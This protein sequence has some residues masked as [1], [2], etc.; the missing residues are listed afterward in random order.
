MPPLTVKYDNSDGRVK[1]DGGDW[2]VEEEG[3]DQRHGP[4]PNATMANKFKKAREGWEAAG[5]DPLRRPASQSSEFQLPVDTQ[6]S[7]LA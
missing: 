1:D 3:C 6:R 7:P 4:F 5:S 2:F